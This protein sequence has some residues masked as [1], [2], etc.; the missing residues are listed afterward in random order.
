Q[1]AAI[2]LNTAKT[3]I[4]A[5]QAAIIAN[6]SGTNTGDQDISGIATNTTN[7]ATNT[8][9][10]SG[11]EADIIVLD[12]AIGAIEIEQTAQD[13]AIDLN[14]AKASESTTVSDTAELDLTLTGT[15]ITADILASS[16]DETKLDA[17]VNASLDLADTALQSFTE[18]DTFDSVTSRGNTTSN[19]ISVRGATVG[20]N[21]LNINGDTTIGSALFM[22]SYSPG[23]GRNLV[24]I[25]QNG[26]QAYG[27][28]DNSSNWNTA[29]SWGNHA[30][31]GYLTSFS[32][33]DPTFIASQAVNIDATDVTNLGNLSGTNS[34]NVT[35]NG[36]S[37]GSFITLLGQELTVNK[38]PLS[39]IA[40]SAAQTTAITNIS[41][42]NTGD[43]DISG[44]ATNATNISGNE[45]DIIVLDTAIGVIETE[46]TTQNSAIGTNATDIANLLESVKTKA[47]HSNNSD[48]TTNLNST[49]GVFDQLIPIFGNNQFIGNTGNLENSSNEY[50]TVASNILTVH[51]TGRII[52][53][54]N[55]YMEA[56]V[57]RASVQMRIKKNGTT[58]VGP[59]ASS[60]YI[61]NGNGHTESSV[62][63]SGFI[64]S[65]VPGDEISFYAKRAAAAGT[66]NMT[67]E[68]S[69]VSI[70]KLID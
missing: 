62:H 6:T 19:D 26:G 49:N 9:N 39:E 36:A 54:A 69:S 20:V 61:R 27:T 46:Q 55:L 56:A 12:T 58:E 14:T 3:G 8:G 70:I 66:V 4:T 65:V 10:I 40:F 23:S 33:S 59:I 53:D 60:G 68:T 64:L 50:F 43:Q 63:I 13:A 18:A 47:V 1:D 34:G 16:I 41:G 57:N 37:E 44:I 17:S 21:G 5:G 2:A 22:P 15:D 48:I 45:A 30:T 25:G 52:I 67:S 24:S 42:T 32:E 35:I 51:F 29:F 38:V 11:N 28:T 7:I 31:E